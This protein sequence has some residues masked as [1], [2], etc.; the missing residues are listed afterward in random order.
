MTGI[1]GIIN[2]DGI[3]VCGH[4][5]VDLTAVDASVNRYVCPTKN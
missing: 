4:E 1:E 3:P 5:K 2:D